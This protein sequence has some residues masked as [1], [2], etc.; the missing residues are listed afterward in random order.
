MRV[1]RPSGRGNAFT[2]DKHRAAVDR[3]ALRFGTPAL[4][5]AHFTAEE[6]P[7]LRAA[8]LLVSLA[9]LGSLVLRVTLAADATHTLPSLGFVP[10]V[11]KLAHPDNLSGLTLHG[12]LLVVCTDEG[13]ALNVLAKN[14]SGQFEALEPVAF[15][16]PPGSEIDAEGVTSDGRWVYVVGA[17]CR[18]RKKLKPAGSYEENRQRLAEIKDEH[19]RYRLFRLA[20]ED[21]G[22]RTET[23]E[24]SLRDLLQHDAILG[25][26][27]RLPSKENGVD[28]EGIAAADGRL[29][30][31]FRA[32][33]LRDNYVPV[34]CL[35]FE[36]P[37][38]Y[39]LLFLR[40]GGRGIRDLAAV[41]EGLL[42]LA[43][44]PG[45]GEGSYELYL[46]NKLDCIPGQGSPGGSTLHLGTVATT[47]GAKPEG[48]AVV[49]QDGEHVT[50]LVVCDGPRQPA[51]ERLKV[52]L[53]RR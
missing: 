47:A 7:Q 14:A 21:D 53:P 4:E 3:T 27:T 40:L 34:V 16:A 2:L 50:L 51:L 30:L 19:S 44:P 39:R 43:G 10:L 25:R 17:H 31:G 12:T 8:M 32:P 41:P 22:R 6:D 24:I 49:E 28:I 5:R 36:R 29:Y 20:L 15:P 23:T 37:E 33:V 52:R 35:D 42:V 45:D 1:R 13:A 38:E 18:S 11:G 48:I 46:W 9:L 26:F